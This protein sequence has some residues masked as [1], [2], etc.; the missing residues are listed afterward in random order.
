MEDVFT[1]RHNKW[2]LEVASR[3]YL[4]SEANNLMRR[5]TGKQDADLEV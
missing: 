2:T 5:A 3:A 4:V 1:L